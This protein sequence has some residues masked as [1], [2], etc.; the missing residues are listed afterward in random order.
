MTTLCDKSAAVTYLIIDYKRKI[1][2]KICKTK[3]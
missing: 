2:E 1:M 3:N